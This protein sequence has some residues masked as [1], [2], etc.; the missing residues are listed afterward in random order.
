MKASFFLKLWVLFS[1]LYL[2]KIM[3]VSPV[4]VAFLLC[5]IFLFLIYLIKDNKN[6]HK[7]SIIIFFSSVLL[8]IQFY[9]TSIPLT[10]NL[11]LTFFSPLL[12]Y[13]LFKNMTIGISFFNT[14]AFFYFSLFLADGVWRLFHPNLEIDQ[15]KL[16]ALGIG[17]HIYKFNS[18]MYIDSNFVGLQAV[19]VLS[20]FL[21]AN[22][23]YKQKLNK[24]ILIL[25]FISILL[26][27]SRAA[28]L[29][30]FLAL[31]LYYIQDSKIKQ[32]FS[33]L[34]MFLLLFVVSNMLS[35]M[36]NDVSFESKFIILEKTAVYLNSVDIFSLFF[37]VGAGKAETVLGIGAHN[38]LVS[39]I[40]ETGILGVI[41]FF[42]YIFYFFL[43]ITYGRVLLIA[44]FIIV[45]MSLSTLAMPY[46]FS[47]LALVSS[48]LS[49]AKKEKCCDFLLI[50]K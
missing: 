32:Y 44:P 1:G 3:P 42:I 19:F 13:G 33:I 47:L 30:A 49:K 48:I 35:F 25:A 41:L 8:L 12:I 28:Y 26:T 46:F 17:F 7:F 20:V 15:A 50:E 29:G 37:G 36:E 11:I 24:L 22:N 34:L 5:F 40:V 16:D 6:I 43:K 2:T 45:S 21:W 14:Y 18:F 23:F 31:F 9:L 38:L 39:L 4:Y 27:I 10:L